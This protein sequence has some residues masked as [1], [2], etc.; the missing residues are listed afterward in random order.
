MF[1]INWRKFII[2][3][4]PSFL[5]NQRM[6]DWLEVAFKPIKRNWQEFLSF[7]QAI[8][9]KLRYNGQTIKLER[10]LNDLYDPIL[11]RI[12]IVKE[13]PKP[14]IT[15]FNREEAKQT[16]VLFNRW[17][18]GV[19]YQ[20]GQFAK[21]GNYV[22]RAIAANINQ[23]PEQWSSW[24]VFREVV[25]L[26]NREEYSLPAFEFTI[27]IPFGLTPNLEELRAQVDQYVF[28]HYNIIFF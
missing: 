3:A 20:P 14:R 18:A 10:L 17:E 4:L 11:R 5:R 25:P 12:H 15:I 24:E 28:K 8:L 6:I 13:K 16:F 1:N 26:R 9:F 27:R 21:V 22:Y 23:N 19:T 7:R 2:L